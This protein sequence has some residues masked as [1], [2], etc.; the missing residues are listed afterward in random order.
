MTVLFADIRNFTTISE[1]LTAAQLKEML[2][3]FFTP[4][5]EII[6]KFHGTIDKYV[7]DM[8]MAFWS[9]PLKDK[10][11]ARHAISAA[12]DMQLAVEK[13]K[14][15]FKEKGWAEVNIGIGLNS[16]LMSV[17]DMGSKFRRNYTVL[18]D[19]VNLA[20]RI[21]GLTKYYGA[22]LMVT[23]N[24]QANQKNFIFRKADRVRVKG[25]KMGVEIYEVLGRTKEL[26]PEFKKEL[27]LYHSAL[28]DYFNQRWENARAILTELHQAHPDVKLYSLYLHRIDEFEKT[29]PPSDWD[30]IYT[31]ATK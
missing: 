28:E 15:V 27:D 1:P 3:E 23:E 12:L 22:K 24:T 29:P 4:M 16:G 5:T 31:H 18:G 30:G 9:A 11:H 7:G 20:S 17:G 8:I 21:E 14:P 26:T 19:A 13:L 25:K 6:F 10:Y 2:N